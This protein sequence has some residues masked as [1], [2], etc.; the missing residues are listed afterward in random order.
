MSYRVEA[1]ILQP[2]G[3]QGEEYFL[4]IVFP[5][6]ELEEEDI[7]DLHMPAIKRPAGKRAIILKF[8]TED[9]PMHA[10]RSAILHFD[11]GQAIR[12]RYE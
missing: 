9:L 10:D 4:K 3:F 6:N 12:D 5:V 1:P 8:K 11:L 7:D 2:L